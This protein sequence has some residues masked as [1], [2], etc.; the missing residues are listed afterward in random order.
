MEKTEFFI[1]MKGAGNGQVGVSMTG[2]SNAG[3]EMEQMLDNVCKV[4][5]TPREPGLYKVHVEFAGEEIRGSPFSVKCQG[6]GEKLRQKTSATVG[7]PMSLRLGL[8]YDQSDS[9]D[10]TAKLV[11]PDG[12]SEGIQLEF[13]D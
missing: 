7:I 6:Q 4:T 9:N 11:G 3:M 13:S 1:G 12:S 2:P 8:G 5:Y 10:L